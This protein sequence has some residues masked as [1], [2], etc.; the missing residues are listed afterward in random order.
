MDSQAGLL[1]ACVP[2]L[3]SSLVGSESGL[4]TGVEAADRVPMHGRARRPWET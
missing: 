4:D 3:W 2:L 1:P